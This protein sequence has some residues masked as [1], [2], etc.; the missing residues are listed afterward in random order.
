MMKLISYYAPLIIQAT[1]GPLAGQ[2][3]GSSVFAAPW[4]GAVVGRIGVSAVPMG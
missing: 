4:G 1:A 3:W 2:E